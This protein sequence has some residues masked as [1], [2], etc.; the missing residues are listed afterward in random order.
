[1]IVIRIVYVNDCV[2]HFIHIASELHCA[3]Y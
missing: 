2:S 1:M 3:L